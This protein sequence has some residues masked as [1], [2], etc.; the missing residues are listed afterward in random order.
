[1]NELQQSFERRMREL[2][3]RVT[4]ER[5]T[6]LEHA[7]RYFGHFDADALLRS[8]QRRG[9]RVSRATVYRTLT[10]LVDAGLLRRYDLGGRH[11]VYEPAFGRTHHEHLVCV[12]CG[13]MY[14]FV[15]QRIEQLQEEVCREHRFVPISHTLQIH[16]ICEPCRRGRRRT[17]SIPPEPTELRPSSERSG[18]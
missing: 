16:G 3:L 13:R 12:H 8:L 17:R 10:H 14:E 9:A 15:Q 1:M 6:V 2:G 18:R 5:R 11:A 7:F 4:A